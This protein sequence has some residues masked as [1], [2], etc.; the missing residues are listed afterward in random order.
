MTE[1]NPAAEAE[2]IAAQI[3]ADAEA[4]GATVKTDVEAIKTDIENDVEKVEGAVKPAETV[5]QTDVA[6]IKTDAGTVETVV[7]ADTT[8][9][10]DAIKTAQAGVQAGVATVKTDTEVAVGNAHSATEMALVYLE[11]VPS[12]LSAELT[13]A[14]Q[15]LHAAMSWF[16]AHLT[17]SAAKA[18]AANKQPAP[19]TA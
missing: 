15:K 6:E 14:K 3:T 11:G 9:A 7:K 13:E 19:P 4:A 1:F 5:A 2:K 18:T 10:A 8:T 17:A 12:F 16:E